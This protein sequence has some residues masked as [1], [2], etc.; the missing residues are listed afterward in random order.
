MA[1]PTDHSYRTA[2]LSAIERHNDVLRTHIGHPI[3]HGNG[4]YLLC[5]CGHFKGT[6]LGWEEHCQAKVIDTPVHT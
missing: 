3:S 2:R 6:F 5:Q 1:R 4:M